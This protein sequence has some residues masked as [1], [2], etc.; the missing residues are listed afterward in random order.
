MKRGDVIAYEKA[1][2]K[3]ESSFG[4]QIRYGNNT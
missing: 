4:D 3:V 1:G 2:E